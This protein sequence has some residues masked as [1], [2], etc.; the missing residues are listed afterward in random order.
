MMR[1]IVLTR[2]GSGSK[3]SNQRSPLGV[4]SGL[5]KSSRGEHG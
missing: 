3:E 1:A 2:S 5:S 4:D